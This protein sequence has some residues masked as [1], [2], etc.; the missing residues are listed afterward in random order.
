MP[1]SDYIPQS[2]KYTIDNLE[3]V[4]YLIDGQK[5]IHIDNGFAFVDNVDVSDIK[6]LRTSSISVTDESSLDERYAFS[7]NLT[8]VV[9]G[10]ANVELLDGKYYAIVRDKNNTYWILNPIFPNKVQHTFT[11]SEEQCQTEFTMSILSNHPL[12]QVRG[13][14]ENIPMLECK[15]Y[16]QRVAGLLLNEKAYT[17]ANDEKVLYSND[18]FKLIKYDKNSITF[19]ETF[20]GDNVSQS[21]QFNIKFSDYKSS[22]HYNLLEFVKNTYAGILE[23]RSGE[24]FAF[25]LTHGLQPSFSLQGS[26]N[27]INSIQITLRGIRANYD[28]P[29]GFISG[30]IEGITSTQWI[31]TSEG[32]AYECVDDGVAI[33]ELEYEADAFGNRTGRYR[34]LQGMESIFSQNYYIIGTY[35]TANAQRFLTNRCATE[36]GCQ[37]NTS[38]SNPTLS[39]A[40]TSLTYSITTNSNWSI[41]SSSSHLTVSPS[42]GSA[43]SSPQSIT[44]NA[45]T[46]PS[47]GETVNLTY[48]FCNGRSMTQRVFISP[49]TTCFANGATNGTTSAS[50]HTITIPYSCCISGVSMVEDKDWVTSLTYGSGYFRVGVAT[51][52]NTAHRMVIINITKCDGSVDTYRL[53]QNG[54][55]TQWRDAIGYT[56]SGTTK[57]QIQ[58]LWSGTTT[59]TAN[60]LP[61]GII[62]AN[63]TGATEPNS[64]DCQGSAQYRWTAT[65]QTYCQDGLLYTVMQHQV[66]YDGTNWTDIQGD[67]TL[68]GGTQ[69]SQCEEEE[70]E[71]SWAID[72]NNPWICGN[73]ITGDSQPYYALG[74]F[75]TIARG[76]GTISFSGATT[77]QTLAYSTNDGQTWSTPQQT[78]TVTVSSGTAVRWRGTNSGKIGR[79][80]ATVPFEVQGNI[81]SLVQTSQFTTADT[82]SSA[83]QFAGLLS[84]ST[85]TKATNLTLNPTVLSTRCYQ[86]MFRGCT[87]LTDAPQLPATSLGSMCYQ[88]MFSGCTSLVNAPRQLPATTLETSCYNSMF[89]GC[90]SLTTVPALPA[91]TLASSCYRAMFAGCTSLQTAP[92]LPATTLADY[93]YYSMFNGC[94]SLENAPVLSAATIPNYGYYYM[95][96]NCSSLTSISMYGTTFGT[97][98]L[99][100]WVNGVASSGTIYLRNGVTLEEGNSGIPSGWRVFYINS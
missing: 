65:T 53:I 4:V 43:S 32:G 48:N 13:M 94:T 57:Y 83:S 89:N 90:T 47:Q 100:N 8:F 99:L 18:G 55:Y 42:N 69:S 36:D 45:N 98:A 37:F 38:L 91:T 92:A 77:G 19:Q 22:W 95:F 81:M 24:N 63:E 58:A 70:Y 41:T 85:V 5:N 72:T 29:A 80:T 1:V 9:Q 3:K 40:Q 60:Y 59:N 12:L 93:C 28:S 78:P 2:C 84:G 23:F 56:C 20:D 62:R 25:G 54:W 15:Y 34:C 27:E 82:I 10:Y 46:F 31:G 79:F 74:Y 96:R 7:H 39:P 33:Y 88:G 11:A 61:T 97:S 68:S 52:A 35:T 86:D 21:L 14:N 66:S 49:V 16:N 51:N 87:D 6:A 75:T 73:G 44:L 50:A 17:S 76:S 71:Y 64:P 26:D 30:A 67:T